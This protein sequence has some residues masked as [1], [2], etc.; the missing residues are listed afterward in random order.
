MIDDRKII[1]P[2]T[3]FNI[4]FSKINENNKKQAIQENKESNEIQKVKKIKK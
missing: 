2:R 3:N 4:D 1:Q